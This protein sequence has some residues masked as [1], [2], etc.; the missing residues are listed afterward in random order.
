MKNLASLLTTPTQGR[1]ICHPINANQLIDC[2]CHYNIDQEAEHCGRQL[3]DEN[4]AWWNLHIL[5]KL[6][7]M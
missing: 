5:R 7:I 4:S 6:F 2:E 1:V 3:H